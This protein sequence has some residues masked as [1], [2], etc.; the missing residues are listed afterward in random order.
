MS[1]GPTCKHVS[2]V[3]VWPPE[4]GTTRRAGLLDSQ[5]HQELRQTLRK[6]VTLTCSQY[7]KKENRYKVEIIL[8]AQAFSLKTTISQD[9]F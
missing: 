6:L 8:K 4:P 1:T 7:L 2:R 5:G 3:W 9:F